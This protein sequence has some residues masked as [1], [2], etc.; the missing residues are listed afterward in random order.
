MQKT[1]NYNLN[2]PDLTDYVDV[3]DLNENMDIIDEA[4]KNLET[5]TNAEVDKKV[6]RSGDTM[7]GVLKAQS[8]ISYT[9]AQVRNIILS[10][11][12][13]DVSLMQNGEIWI[14]YVQE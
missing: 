6:D 8:N 5:T 7:N 12:D 11:T 10:P 4:I 14:K 3:T 13:A 1:T 9:T 2:K